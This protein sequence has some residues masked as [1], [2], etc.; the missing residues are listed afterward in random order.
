M[1]TANPSLKTP[2]ASLPKNPLEI[3]SYDDIG[4]EGNGISGREIAA[5]VVSLLV[6]VA[7]LSYFWTIHLAV[8]SDP[9]MDI[10]SEE[11]Q[12]DKM[13]IVVATQN[14][15]VGTNSENAT[16]PNSISMARLKGQNQQ[17]EL[18]QQLEETNIEAPVIETEPVVLPNREELISQVVAKGDTV[19]TGGT[20]GAIDIL[21]REIESSLAERKT[22]VIWL[23][24]ASQSLNKRRDLIAKRFENVYKQLGERNSDL[25]EA[26]QTA[27]VSYGEKTKFIT[28][29]PVNDVTDVVK[30]VRKI[31]PDES[32]KEYVFTAINEILQKWRRKLVRYKTSAANRRNVRL[33]IVTDERGDDYAGI[34]GKNY[35]YLDHTI[36]DLR[37]LNV[38]VYCVGNAAVFGREKGFV[39]FTDKTGYKWDRIEVDQ[40]PETVA[41]ER[42]QLPF[43]GRTNYDLD[44]LSANYGPFA[45]TRVCAETGGLFF[46]TEHS[47]GA[48][49]FP[50]DVMRNYR[51]FYGTI[52]KYLDTVKK[53]RARSALYR[54]AGMT[55]KT[56]IPRPK[57]AFRADNDNILRQEMAE[58]QRP[59]ARLN[60]RLTELLTVL[61]EGEKDR[62]K[63]KEPRWRAGYDLAMGRLLAM[64]VR[65]FG[66]QTT[67]A[68]MSSSPLTFKKKGSNQW[69]LVP[70]KKWDQ[71][72]PRVKKLAK[73]AQKY[74][75]RVIDEHPNTPWALLAEHE[76]STEMGW[77]WQEGRMVIVSQ[78]GNNANNPNQIQLA[79]ETPEQRRERMRK[80]QRPKTKPKL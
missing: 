18:D 22:L 63:L 39:S 10:T 53:N 30:A 45:L 76:L 80:K 38:R 33:I 55:L 31:Q 69:R 19:E 56:P 65:A 11:T 70:S 21:A 59:L 52:E 67:L 41:P 24:D 68:E 54:V 34:S 42:L 74:L 50:P 60:Y 29:E 20:E 49:K 17:K 35:A 1:A 26:L 2:R 36:R 25:N 8:E 57:L 51:P 32:G 12:E 71:Y 75:K 13:A 28:D 62:A 44:R 58:A 77:Q 40:G 9:R 61:S 79:N 43:W 7:I 4:S 27:V 78:A 72:P 15:E 73:L 64:K 14:D 23:F 5:W 16:K 66:Y 47:Q 37:R 3:V 6:N 46:I 48:A